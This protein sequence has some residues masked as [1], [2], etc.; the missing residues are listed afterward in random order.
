MD[1]CVVNLINPSVLGFGENSSFV[2]IVMLDSTSLVEIGSPVE[3]EKV[4]ASS[5]LVSWNS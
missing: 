4:D 3:I 5:V 2:E 1:S